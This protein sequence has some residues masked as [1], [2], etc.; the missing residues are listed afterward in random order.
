MP[1]IE[2]P[3]AALFATETNETILASLGLSDYGPEYPDD[4]SIAER[5]TGYTQTTRRIYS[6]LLVA[7]L[8][9][10]ESAITPGDFA[11]ALAEIDKFRSLLEV[12]QD[13]AS[14]MDGGLPFV[15]TEDDANVLVAGLDRA[16]FRD[17]ADYMTPA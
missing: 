5:L 3:T 9:R 11:R 10:R 13:V 17:C 15:G 8:A 12:L 16:P 6:R 7:A 1:T 2:Q 4:L 14:I